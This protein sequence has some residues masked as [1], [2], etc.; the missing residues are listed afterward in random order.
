MPKLT[1]EDRKEI[2]KIVRNYQSAKTLSD[3]ERFVQ[4]LQQK[5]EAIKTK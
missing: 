1:T 3:K 5:V 2:V 4:E